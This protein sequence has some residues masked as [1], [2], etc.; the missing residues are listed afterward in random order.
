M[1]TDRLEELE[2]RFT[3]Q[4]KALADLNDV[5][6]RQRKEL[7]ELRLGYRHLLQRMT[8]M[9]DTGISQQ[10]ANEVPPHY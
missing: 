5:I 6:I 2:T 10:H 1:D 3:Y 7:D 9:N 4:E 8:S